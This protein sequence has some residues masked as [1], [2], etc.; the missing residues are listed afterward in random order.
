M[1]NFVRFIV[2]YH[3]FFFFLALQFLCFFLIYS[4]NSFHQANFVN[5]SNRLI[6]TLFSWKSTLTEYIE[7]QRVNDELALENQEL[8]NQISESF[9]V[10]NDQF[11]MIN[12]TLSERKFRYKS[13]QIVNSSINKQLNFI[14]INKGSKEGLKPEMGVIG[15]DGLVGVVKE[16]SSHFSTVIPIVNRK[17]I[18]SAELKR[19]G[20][21]GLLK[22][23][24]EDYQYANL[25]DVPSH[26]QV[27]IGD[28]IVT[29]GASAIYPKGIVIGVISEVA[30]NAGSNFH[31]ITVKLNVDFNRLRYVDVIENLWKE[32]QRE[33]ETL[34]EENAE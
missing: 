7:L 27:L 31:E 22:W 3:I 12:D 24:G 14:T 5:S 30:E 33:L 28:T 1:R 15:N 25:I 8:R 29:R 16:V 32:E 10:V 21:F 11:V 13:A 26:V 17:F 20:N 19:T 9:E 4:N 2:K 23:D 6:G 18:A 34:T